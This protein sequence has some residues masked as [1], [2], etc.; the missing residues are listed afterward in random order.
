MESAL[1]LIL[2]LVALRVVIDDIDRASEGREGGIVAAVCP[3]WCILMVLI[4]INLHLLI[5]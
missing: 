3:G 5:F 1:A 2:R 4:S